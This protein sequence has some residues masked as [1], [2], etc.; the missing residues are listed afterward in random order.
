MSQLQECREVVLQKQEV[1]KNAKTVLK[2]EFFGIDRVIDDVVD[3]LSSWYIFP[4]MQ[5]KPLIINLWGLTGVGKSSLVKRLVQLLDFNKYYYPF[6]LGETSSTPDSINVR[7]E[8][9][10]MH[11]KKSGFPFIIAFDE[12]QH[13]RTISQLG[14]ETNRPFNRVVWQL[15]D[16][17]MFTSY[18][19]YSV[20]RAIEDILDDVKALLMRG[21]KVER[22]VVVKNLERYMEYYKS[23]Y[24][25]ADLSLDDNPD[26]PGKSRPFISPDRYIDIYDAA[27]ELF[28]TPEEVKNRLLSYNGFETM[29]FLKE[30]LLVARRPK[31]VDCRKSLVFVMGNLDEAFE[32]AGNQNADIS[33]DEFH[34][35]SLNINLPEIKKALKYRFRAEQIARLGNHHVIYPAFSKRTYELIIARELQKLAGNAREEFG[36]KLHFDDALR[37]L[38]YREGVFPTQGTRPV[39]TTVYRLVTARMGAVVSEMLIKNL[40]HCSLHFSAN[41]VG[42]EV[43]FRDGKQ[44]HYHMQFKQ[45]LELEKL[46]KNKQDDL[47]AITA[48]H[49][50]GH[51]ILAAVLL[52]VLPEAVFSNTV[53]HG[54]SGFALISG[55]WKYISR[56]EITARLAMML[57]GLMAEKVVFGEDRVT[58]G[59]SSD[60]SHATELVTKM[61]KECGMGSALG[62]F[63]VESPLNNT[64]LFDNDY[65]LNQEA[66]DWISQ[67]AKLAEDTLRKQ[68]TLLLH[69]ADYL[70]DHRELNRDEMLEML[71]AHAVDFDPNTII[72]NGDLLF[73]RKHLKSRIM[74][75]APPVHLNL[76][77]HRK[78]I[79][80]NRESGVEGK[81][82]VGR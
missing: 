54:S 44:A 74:K 48:V 72:E 1:L 68:E 49:E 27:P 43:S 55:K 41:D 66:V 47:Q 38:L 64:F 79:L 10:K 24:S 29:E 42:V 45:E 35:R 18:P 81:R 71:K 11:E 34:E 32:M 69:M 39:F 12:F 13:A 33:A 57:G 21:V 31:E 73:Y 9:E 75:L 78:D 17:G 6:D 16:S 67:A 26:N 70:S 65:R 36:L 80:L 20:T 37:G 7:T 50:S 14:E 40:E 46:R 82:K 2:K 22:G 62:S 52:R 30:V 56:S 77:N 15:L 4:Y 3:T 23:S 19:C 61:L 59:A 63:A 76:A 58:T 51:A 8:L 28:E 53:D 60:L 25:L 5:E